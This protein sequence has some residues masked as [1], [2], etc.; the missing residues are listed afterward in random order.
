MPSFEVEAP[1]VENVV[2]DS[3]DSSHGEAPSPASQAHKVTPSKL[4]AV[5]STAFVGESG[6]PVTFKVRTGR[7]GG[8]EEPAWH[9]GM[10]PKLV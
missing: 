10:P 9:S 3:K 8:Q 6:M 4:K 1:D 7:P 2:K 5:L